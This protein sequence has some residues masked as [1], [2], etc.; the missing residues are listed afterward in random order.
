MFICHFL[1]FFPLPPSLP[2]N[3]RRRWW[4]WRASLTIF[5]PTPT[6]CRRFFLI[7]SKGQHCACACIRD[8]TVG[9]LR[10]YWWPLC[11]LLQLGG[12]MR[13]PSVHCCPHCQKPGAAERHQESDFYIW[14]VA[15]LHCRFS[16]TQW[17]C[18][19]REDTQHNCIL[20]TP[21]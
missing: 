3:L 1:L 12:G 6:F 10:L 20:K 13:G 14:E 15:E 8:G 5:P 9:W 19:G 7:S 11:L 18:A 17:V 2:S 16:L 4:S 21:N